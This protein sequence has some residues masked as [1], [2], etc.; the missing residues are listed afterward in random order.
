[1]KKFAYLFIVCLLLAGCAKPAS[2]TQ[3]TRTVF[4]MDTVMNLTV[5]GDS[6]DDAL[7]A[8]ERELYRLDALFARGRAGSAVYRW[9]HGETPDDAAFTELLAETERISAATDGAFDPYLGG[10]LDLWGFGSGAGEHRV[11]TEAELA[12]APRLLDFGGVAKGYA[13]ERMFACMKENGVSSAVLD[14]GGDVALWGGK[15]DGPWRVAIKDP[16]D[17]DAYLGILETDGDRFIMTSGVY[18]RRFEENGV[19]YHHII[20]PATR[21]PADSGVVSATVICQNGVWTDALATVCCVVGAEKALAL[22]ASLADMMPFDLILVTDDGHV[23][24]T[25]GGFVGESGNGYAY[26]K[27]A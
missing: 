9:N 13:G 23:L 24:Y 1:M 18:E 8:A 21:H 25:C 3:H 5:Y 4:A 14:L 10:V 16:A 19:T 11:P 6:G 7:T 20:D 22:R 26:E 17:G 15:P 2:A 27:V 12:D